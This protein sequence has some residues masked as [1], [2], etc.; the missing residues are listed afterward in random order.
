MFPDEP[1]EVSASAAVRKAAFAPRMTDPL[2]PALRIITER[3]CWPL[4]RRSTFQ[5]ARRRARKAEVAAT[6]GGGRAGYNARAGST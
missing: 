3:L 2:T 1:H 5:D 6:S 4:L